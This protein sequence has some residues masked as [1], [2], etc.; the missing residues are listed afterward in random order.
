MYSLVFWLIPASESYVRKYTPYHSSEIE[1]SYTK[2]ADT[3]LHLFHL[4]LRYSLS[5]SIRNY[6]LYKTMYKNTT[7]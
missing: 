4:I 1:Y 5:A 2:L 3:L 7:N 6:K